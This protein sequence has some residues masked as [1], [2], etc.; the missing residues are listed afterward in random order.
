M[1]SP[2]G[3][4][5]PL[6]PASLAQLMDVTLIATF[7]SQPGHTQEK[8]WVQMHPAAGGRGDVHPRG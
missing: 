2:G 8:N 3:E 1:A 5:S 7:S 4:L 6:D